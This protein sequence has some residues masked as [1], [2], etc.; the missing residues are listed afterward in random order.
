V[1]IA[2]TCPHLSFAGSRIEVRQVDNIH[3]S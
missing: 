1:E 3:R 2:R